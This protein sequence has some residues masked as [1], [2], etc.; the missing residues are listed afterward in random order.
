[1]TQSVGTDGSAT[2]LLPAP[3]GA[4]GAFA[5]DTAAGASVGAAVAGGAA[6][7]VLGFGT[8][9][10]LRFA[11]NLLLTR[12][13]APHVFGVIGLVNLVLQGLHMF[14]DLGIRQS[15]VQRP[16]GD[17]PDFLD[18][19]WT[20]GV[21]RGFALG[22][23]C[24]AV[25]WP[26]ALFYDEP[27]MLWLIPLVGLT[28]VL[29]GWQSAGPMLLSRRLRRGRLVAQ[30]LFSYVASMIVVLAG[31]WLLR[32]LPPGRDSENLRLLVLVAG[33]VLSSVTDLIISFR[34]VPGLRHRFR[35]DRAALRELFHFGGWITLST[36][37]T[38]LAATADKPVV[39]KL[40]SEVLGAY[41]PA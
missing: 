7:T 13:L 40:S 23:V 34:Q 2:H 11:F 8:M 38:F 17:D 39:G 28:A 6:W 12:L 10:V 24:A 32:D 16:D 41:E 18:T 30:E 26:L 31:L 5:P 35:W 14:S 36:A 20:L 15:V 37:C 25:A 9:Q 27:A 19:A 21:V 29:D 1:M 3:A 33:N 22:L 4:D